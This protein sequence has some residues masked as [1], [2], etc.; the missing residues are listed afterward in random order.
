MNG[1]FYLQIKLVMLNLFCSFNNAHAGADMENSKFHLYN[2]LDINVTTSLQEITTAVRKVWPGVKLSEISIFTQHN[3][4]IVR[5]GARVA[6]SYYLRE[7][8][9][10]FTPVKSKIVQALLQ[11]DNLATITT[12]YFATKIPH[13]ELLD[14]ITD[15]IRMK[16]V[17][18][19]PERN[20][21]VELNWE[22]FR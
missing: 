4:D 9:K 18:Y 1:F 3:N 2:T 11:S 10:R 8:G 6:F 12:L 20:Q 16:V 13:Q 21:L 19:Y 17:N 5:I 14:H 7:F 15:L 22:Y